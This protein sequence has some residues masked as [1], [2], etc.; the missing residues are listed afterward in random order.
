MAQTRKLQLADPRER[1][2]DLPIEVLIGGEYYWRIVQDAS[3]IRLSSS[4]VLLPTKFGWILPGNRTGITANHMAVNHIALEHAD[5][6]LRKFWDLETIGIT[7]PEE[8]PLTVGESQILQEFRDS[9]CIEDG[10]RVLR[11]PK[12]NICEVSPNRSNAEIRFRSL[13]QRLRQHDALRAI[14]EGQMIDHVA[15]QHVKLAPHTEESMGGFCMQHH[16]VKRECRGKIKWRIVFDASSNKSNSPSLN[17]VLEMGPNLLPEVLATLLRFCEHPL[18]IIGDSQQAFLQLPLDCK[19][20]DLTR[21]FWYR[22]SHDGKG[23]YYTTNDVV[24]YRFTRLPFGLHVAHS[25]Y[26]RL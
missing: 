10:R 18:G 6:D 4:L 15:K 20:R 16:V 9:Y 17:D 8:A 5:N 24:T 11:L 13:Q 14:Y 26:Q 3:T 12:K 21:F 2:R 7:S 22:V 23:T 1:D 25:C 19:N